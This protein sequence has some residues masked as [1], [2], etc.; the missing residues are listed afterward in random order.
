[1]VLFFVKFGGYDTPIDPLR[2]ID[3]LIENT[4]PLRHSCRS[5]YAPAVGLTANRNERSFANMK[6]ILK[7][8]VQGMSNCYTCALDNYY[9]I[10]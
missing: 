6:K 2:S 3:R 8:L 7:L 1:M 5:I 4:P 9:M 10:H